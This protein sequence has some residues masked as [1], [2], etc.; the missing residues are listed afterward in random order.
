MPNINLRAVNNDQLR[1]LYREVLS[2]DGWTVEI[3]RSNHVV[4]S[5]PDGRKTFGP[6]TTSD[7]ARVTKNVRKQLRFRGWTAPNRDRQQ[8]AA[9]AEVTSPTEVPRRKAV[10]PTAVIEPTFQ[11]GVL[12][13][14]KQSDPE[15]EPE[16][17][18]PEPQG[19]TPMSA[20]AAVE[21]D[22][23]TPRKQRGQWAENVSSLTRGLKV[24]DPPKMRPRGLHAQKAQAGRTGNPGRRSD[25]E[26][27]A[28]Q[29]VLE[30]LL[31][32]ATE[33]PDQWVRVPGKHPYSMQ[34][35]FRKTA[36]ELDLE[37]KVRAVNPGA[38]PHTSL[39]REELKNVSMRYWVKVT[40]PAADT[41][42]DES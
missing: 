34:S 10:R 15:P 12:E 31:T 42:D 1:E 25:L 35:L 30:L 36:G 18:T 19:V 8:A 4:M 28:Y 33:H 14:E 40:D 5:G 13:Y 11:Y 20:V 26:Y 9:T 41:D 27:K 29:L 37:V 38:T 16:A 39:S 17:A 24:E 32:A 23:P 6:V 3:T 21:G 22:E 7:G 2:T